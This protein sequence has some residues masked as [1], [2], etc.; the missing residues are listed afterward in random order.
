[1]F[2]SKCGIKLGEGAVFCPKCGVKINYNVSDHVEASDQIEENANQNNILGKNEEGKMELSKGVSIFRWILGVLHMLE[3]PFT[4]TNYY[5]DGIDIFISI[6]FL[7]AGIVIIPP[8]RDKINPK[9]NI[10]IFI[11]CIVI[12][13]GL[14]FAKPFI[15]Q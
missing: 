13:Y 8:T 4:L 7:I 2:C 6:L 11:T 14:W 3:L 5:R 1:M 15:I 10:R 9:R 12:G